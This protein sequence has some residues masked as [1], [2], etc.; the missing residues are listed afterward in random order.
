MT[1][2]YFAGVLCPDPIEVSA[3]VSLILEM[4]VYIRKGVRK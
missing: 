4:P 2:W 3:E 1:K